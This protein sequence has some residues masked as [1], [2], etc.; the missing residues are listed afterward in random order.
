QVFIVPNRRSIPL[1][2]G[3]QLLDELLNTLHEGYGEELFPKPAQQYLNDWCGGDTPF[4]STRLPE[5]GSDEP[6]LDLLP[7]VEKAIDWV[8]SLEE[9]KFIG[10]ESRLLTIFRLL[11]ELAQQT[12]EDPTLRIAELERQKAALDQQIER[13]RAGKMD[14]FD[15]TRIRERYFEIEDTAR[16]L[17]SDFRQVEENFR[18][19]DRQTRAKIAT[20]TAQRGLLLDDIF[21]QQ[22]MIRENDQGKSFRAFWEYLMDPSRQDELDRVIDKV[23]ALQDVAAIHSSSF[24][25]QIR[26]NLLDAGDKVYQT[27]SQL[28]AQLRKFLDDQS[29]LEN[30]HIAAIIAKIENNAVQIRD[31]L[32]A[33]VP[34]MVLDAS[35]VD[36]ALTMSRPLYRVSQTPQLDAQ[37]LELGDADVDMSLLHDQ[38]Y[39]DKRVLQNHI[40]SSLQHCPQITLAELCEEFPPQQGVAE[41]MT[42][43][44]LACDDDDATVNSEQRQCIV[45][46]NAGQVVNIPQVIFTCKKDL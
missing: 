17:L 31:R 40:Y 37:T 35:K 22:D 27:Q 20:S 42:Y 13:I 10:T 46:A 15:G 25:A 6:E 4:L 33:R 29:Y 34:G 36:V 45:L 5:Y 18:E 7:A 12:E 23:L 11:Q 3:V 32:S 30:K 2:E 8:R 38:Q 43:L 39:V 16:R 14:A 41:I 28:S 24:L 44:Q 19:L 26:V 1:S 21:R 9:Q